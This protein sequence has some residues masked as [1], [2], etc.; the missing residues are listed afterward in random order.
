V[1]GSHGVPIT[2]PDFLTKNKNLY[3]ADRLLGIRQYD[4]PNPIGG[5]IKY[6]LRGA[7]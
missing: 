6:Q 2:L 7:K 4:Q 5:I 1:I 3:I